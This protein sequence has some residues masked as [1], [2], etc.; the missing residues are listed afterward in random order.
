MEELRKKREVV[1][2]MDTWNEIMECVQISVILT[3]RER[4]REAGV[5]TDFLTYIEPEDVWVM[6]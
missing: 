3:I 5:Q 4:K 6:V 1:I 2:K